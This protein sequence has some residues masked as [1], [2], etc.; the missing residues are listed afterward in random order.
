MK[1][2]ITRELLRDTKPS[3]KALDIADTEVKGFTVRVSPSGAKSYGIRYS[4]KGG[5]QLRYSLSKTFPAT[6]VSDARE[7]AR[8]LLGR[9]AAGENPAAE[10]QE[11]RRGKLTLFG[12]IDTDYGGHLK[13]KARTAA[14]TIFR[15]KQCFAEFRDRPLSEIDAISIDRWR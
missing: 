1:T 6:S 11:A 2:K 3:A 15:L 7:E 13:S 14:A 10:K 9:I 12:F 4:D 8:I 5:K